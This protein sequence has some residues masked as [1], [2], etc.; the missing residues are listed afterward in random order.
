MSSRPD[1]DEA[2]IA[3]FVERVPQALG[4]LLARRGVEQEF[5]AEAT[6]E[7]QEI[8]VMEAFLQPTVASKDHG[9]DH[10]R[11]EV[12]TGALFVAEQARL[13]LAVPH[14]GNQ[15]A[16]IRIYSTLTSHCLS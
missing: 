14:R 12:R 16:E 4:Q 10:A 9:E 3:R 8:G 5:D 1:R 2:R 6:L 11:V 15:K 13:Y 7:R